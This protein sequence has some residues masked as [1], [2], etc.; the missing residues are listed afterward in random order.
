M[1]LTRLLWLILAAVL[2]LALALAIAG[3][4]QLGGF[5]G[6]GVL[7]TGSTVG[8]PSPPPHPNV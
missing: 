2:G 7:A 1:R 8:G 4:N 3:G 5:A 6:H